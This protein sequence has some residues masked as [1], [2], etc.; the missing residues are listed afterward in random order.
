MREEKYSEEKCSEDSHSGESSL[1]L[2]EAFAKLETVVEKLEQPE[3][4][5][6]ESFLAYKEGISLVS[7]CNGMIDRV[8]KDVKVLSQGG[9]IDEL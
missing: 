5:L 3:T 2:E 8:E 1:S 4:S 7:L 6:E 9:T